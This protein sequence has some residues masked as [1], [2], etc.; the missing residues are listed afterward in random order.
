MMEEERSEHQYEYPRYLFTREL[1]G[2]EEDRVVKITLMSMVFAP[3]DGLT[4]VA[5]D[6][7]Y[8]YN[9]DKDVDTEFYLSME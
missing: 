3:Q 8:E 4:K 2:H 5:L 7:Q 1:V 9:G 6:A